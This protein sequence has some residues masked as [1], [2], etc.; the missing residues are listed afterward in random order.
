MSVRCLAIAT[1]MI[2]LTVTSMR[3]TL[4]S[5]MGFMFSLPS[6]AMRTLPKHHRPTGCFS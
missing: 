3:S 5:F 4:L 6:V 1:A 2:Q